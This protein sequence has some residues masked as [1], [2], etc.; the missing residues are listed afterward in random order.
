MGISNHIP[1]IALCIF[2]LFVTI[3]GGRMWFKQVMVQKDCRKFVEG[4]ITGKR[5]HMLEESEKEN[6]NQLY[7]FYLTYTY[8]V[9]GVEYS[10]EVPQPKTENF[11]DSIMGDNVFVYYD[12]KNPKRSFIAQEKVPEYYGM[13]ITAVGIVILI[14]A[15]AILL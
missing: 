4:K 6:K 11:I 5:K 14:F 13:L 10:R 7:T 12:A 8:T 3:K 15:P 1:L 2:G 9:E